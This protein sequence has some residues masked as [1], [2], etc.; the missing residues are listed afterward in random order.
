MMHVCHPPA[1]LCAWHALPS[2]FFLIIINEVY[3][4]CPIYVLIC[5]IAFF[6]FQSDRLHKVLEYINEVHSLCGVLGLDFGKTVSE[7]HPSLRETGPGNSTNISNNTLDGLAQTI[8]KLKL[9]KKNRVQKVRDA[10][11]MTS[12]FAYVNL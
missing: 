7:V 10:S 4:L 12:T 6:C 11:C 2:V 8:L 1:F 9:E 3:Y 5:D